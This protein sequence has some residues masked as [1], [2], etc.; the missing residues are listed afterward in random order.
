VGD[1]IPK[2]TEAKRDRVVAQVIDNL[3]RKFKAL[4]SLRAKKAPQKLRSQ[5]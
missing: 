4:D 5:H 3:L 2:I 1:P